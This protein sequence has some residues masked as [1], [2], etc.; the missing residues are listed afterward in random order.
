[1]GG[2]EAHG[3]AQLP[4][5]AILEVE[6]DGKIG[7]LVAKIE[8]LDRETFIEEIAGPEACRPALMPPT[9]AQIDE[10]RRAGALVV[11]GAEVEARLRLQV[12]ADKTAR[13]VFI[14]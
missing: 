2:V 13:G 6:L 11:A 4:G 3:Q 12:R 8:S 10:L 9:E 14:A 5:I 1:M 7:G